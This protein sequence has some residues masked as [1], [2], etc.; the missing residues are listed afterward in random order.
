MEKSVHIK[1]QNCKNEVVIIKKKYLKWG[2]VLSYERLKVRTLESD[3]LSF[4]VVTFNKSLN[5]SALTFLVPKIRVIL[6]I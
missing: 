5:C 3:R 6:P 4:K 2:K 1:E